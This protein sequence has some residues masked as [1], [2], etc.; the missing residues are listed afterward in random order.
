MVLKFR[1]YDVS[2]DFQEIFQALGTQANRSVQGLDLLL[3]QLEKL[4]HHI[5]IQPYVV[6][7]TLEIKKEFFTALRNVKEY[8]EDPCVQKYY[9]EERFD[10]LMM[11]Y[12]V[13]L[14]KR[15]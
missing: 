12:A 8:R 2:Y 3:P 9:S 5:E 6:E 13:V 1:N 10:A 11:Q 14:R 15:S 4:T 7:K